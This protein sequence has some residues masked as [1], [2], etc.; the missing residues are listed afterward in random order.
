MIRRAGGIAGFGLAAVF[1]VS[2][3]A[4][5]LAAT[6]DI[7]SADRMAETFDKIVF[8]AEFGQSIEPRVS[9][10][11]ETLN[12]YLDIRA[13]DPTLY[14]RL[15]EAHIEE[16][17]DLTGLE[18]LLVPS[19]DDANVFMVFDRD[20]ELLRSAADYQPTIGQH[21]EQI[22]KTL[23]FGIY[24]VNSG[25]EI[26]RAVIGIPTDR[27]A[28]LGKLPACVVEEMTQVMGLPNDS[29]DISPSIFN[30][31]SEDNEL[32]DL[33]R[34]LVRLLYDPAM[35]PGMDR[36]TALAQIRS[37]AD[38]PMIALLQRKPRP[39]TET[40]AAASRTNGDLSQDT[41]GGTQDGGNDGNIGIHADTGDGTG[42]DGDG[43]RQTRDAGFASSI[44]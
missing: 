15:V 43:N 17:G 24:S 6:D 12:V 29:D 20:E 11:V 27:A 23:C 10:W 18:I 26:K 37:L 36:Q 16:L 5:S 41:G 1:G 13:G 32:T 2:L 22:A 33:D 28:S 38:D 3:S 40:A 19:P 9:K 25:F 14:Q 7:A 44:D 21:A 8:H 35:K 30:D 39:G 31:S 34:W 42:A 4:A